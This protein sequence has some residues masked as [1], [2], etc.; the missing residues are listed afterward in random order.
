MN[1]VKPLINIDEL[2]LIAKQRK[3]Q[4]RYYDI[5]RYRHCFSGDYEN[6]IKNA[7]EVIDKTLNHNTAN[8]REYMFK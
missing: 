1:L 8:N 5:K 6:D 2:I 4:S 3:D 7:N